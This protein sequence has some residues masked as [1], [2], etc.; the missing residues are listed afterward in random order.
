[1]LHKYNIYNKVINLLLNICINVKTLPKYLNKINKKEKIIYILQKKSKIDLLIL[2]KQCHKQKLPDP[3]KSIKINNKKIPRCIFIKNINNKF[4]FYIKNNKNIE[5]IN[6]YLELEKKNFNLNL[7]ILPILILIGRKPKYK[8][9]KNI[10]NTKIIKIIKK[11][12]QIIWI[13][14]ETF[15]IFSKKISLKNISLKNISKRSLIKKLIYKI[16]TN[17]NKQKFAIIGPN[18]IKRNKLLK[19][20]LKS[21]I[22]KNKIKKE[23]KIKNKNKKK[24]KYFTLSIIK[25]IATN[26]SYEMIRI[27]NKIMKIVWNKTFDEIIIN[28]SK[29]ICKLAYKGNRIIYL[30][31]H[32]SHIDYLILSYAIYHQGL[33]IP[34]IAAGTNL[35]FWPIGCLFRK[36]GA[37]FIRR[38][39][40]GN[41]LYSII[42]KEYLIK[43]IK[44]GHSIEYFIE[45]SRS[46]TGYLLKPKTGI[47]TITIKS[48]LKNINKPIILVPI[49]INY[50]HIMEVKT[51]T[52]EM[53]GHL[54]KN[55]NILQIVKG[56]K[57]I[58]NFGNSY[59]N[60]GKPLNLI[61]Y[62]NKNVKKWKQNLNFSK[63]KNPNWL[64]PIA[65]NIANDIMNRINAAVAINSINLCATILLSVKK[66]QINKI[67][68]VKQI[69]CYIKLFKIAPYS[70]YFTFPK[71]SAKKIL[72][73]AIKTKKIKLKKNK[74]YDLIVLNEKINILN[75]YKNNIQH[76]F[77]IPSLII[78]IIKKYKKIKKKKIIDKI[79]IIYPIFKNEFFLY[80]NKKKNNKF[81]IRVIKEFI[82]QKLII[83]KKLIFYINTN[84]NNKI[85]ILSTHIN[86][87]LKKYITIISILK[88]NPG[89]NTIDLYKK[90]K[91]LINHQNKNKIPNKFKL[92][93]KQTLLSSLKTFKKIGYIK[94]KKYKKKIENTY[95]LLNKLIKKINVN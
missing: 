17:F 73:K 45:G 61:K 10:K 28:G 94:N 55:E 1:M 39:F 37:F 92:Y 82:N 15:I 6:K 54:K 34:Y 27:V 13:G 78:K 25:E 58:K 30:P 63:T 68:M 50:D 87:I 4:L 65:N 56:I 43:L 44:R 79:N 36:L 57:N 18:I 47:L 41:K 16:N 74:N 90:S 26:F 22:I 85:E 38:T 29:K 42:F 84:K 11:I 51:Y 80:L 67:K 88:L 77:V 8:N 95:K 93:N 69:K 12:L 14:K 72:K 9:N 2:K 24:I 31:C 59:I 35:N 19:K 5:L 7:K 70:K 53:S 3:T 86:D 89:I 40:I 46:R 33:S 21:K 64:I 49:Y 62:L 20:I 91:I 60:F 66:H 75:Y 81:I 83:K 76:I 32:K 52:K 23:I 48:L 71:K